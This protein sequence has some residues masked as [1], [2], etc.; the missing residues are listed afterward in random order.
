M[1]DIDVANP[2]RMLS[3]Y[4]IVAAIKRPPPDIH[5]KFFFKENMYVQFYLPDWSPRNVRTLKEYP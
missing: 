2:L 5:I 4:L 3:A 1:I